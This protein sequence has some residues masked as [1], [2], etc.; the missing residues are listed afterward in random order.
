MLGKYGRSQ[1]NSWF[2]EECQILLEDKK[3]AYNKIRNKNT[4]QN[5]Q[6]HKARNK[7]ALKIFRQTDSI[8][9]IKAGTN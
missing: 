2:D 1:R 9:K 8:F 5:K 7:E 6:E 3:R 4:R